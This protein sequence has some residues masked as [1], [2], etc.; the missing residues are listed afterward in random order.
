MTKVELPPETD[1]AGQE[2][3]VGVFVCH[4][5]KNIGGF[6]DVPS[7]T[8][9]AKTLPNVVYA[10]HNLYTCSSDTQT[11]I[12]DRIIEHNLNRVIEIGRAHV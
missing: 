7:V 4:C 2:P 1:I 3:R 8:E 10:A 12:R 11:V 9:Y 6:V 5:G